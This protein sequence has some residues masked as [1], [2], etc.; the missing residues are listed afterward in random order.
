L[1]DLTDAQWRLI[2]PL[3]PSHH[4]VLMAEVGHAAT[5]AMWW[6]ASCG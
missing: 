5:C 2:E 4:A 6:T 1:T 3:S